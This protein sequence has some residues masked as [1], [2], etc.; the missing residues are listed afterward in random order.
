VSNFDKDFT[1]EPAVLTPIN[2]VLSSADQK[3]FNDFTY[4]AEWAFQARVAAACMPSD[5]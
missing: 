5:Q 2:A 3:E 4:I 1:A